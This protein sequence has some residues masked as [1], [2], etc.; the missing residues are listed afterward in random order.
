[1]VFLSCFYTYYFIWNNYNHIQYTDN[2]Y[3]IAI[4]VYISI[5]SDAGYT[6]RCCGFR[7]AV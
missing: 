7:K 6:Q 5:D 2:P 4:F 3:D 1:M